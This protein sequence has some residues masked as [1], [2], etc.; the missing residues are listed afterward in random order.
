MVYLLCSSLIKRLCT[1][2][3]RTPFSFHSNREIP[4]ASTPAGDG[5]VE[6]LF[7]VPGKPLEV[8]RL[9]KQLDA[10]YVLN[11]S[12]RGVSRRPD[13]LTSDFDLR[14]FDSH[15]LASCLELWLLNLPG[16]IVPEEFYNECVKNANRPD[17][18]LLIIERIPSVSPS[19][20]KRQLSRII[21]YF[22]AAP[23]I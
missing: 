10:R 14:A 3:S 19:G 18:T 12:P 13:F 11:A 22:R 17:Q 7:R 15:A 20:A 16:T 2:L 4:C 1:A 5:S 23:I 9:K 8:E 6:G 21:A